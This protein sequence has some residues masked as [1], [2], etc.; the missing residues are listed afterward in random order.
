MKLPGVISLRKLFADLP[1]SERRLAARGRH[2]IGEVD[3][4]A[5]RGLGA[6]IVQPLLGLDGPEIGLEHHVELAWLCPLPLGATVRADDLGHR[7]RI[8]IGDVLL[9]RVGLLHVVLAMPVVAAQALHQRVVEDL[10]VAGGHPHRP[11][12]D[13]RRVEPHHV[14]ATGDHSAPPLPLDVLLELHAQRTVI[15]RRFGAAVD[16]TRGKYEATPFGQVDYGVD[17]GR[18]E[19]VHFLPDWGRARGSGPLRPKHQSW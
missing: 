15:P 6:Q 11:R 4:D 13:D 18:Q 1:D 14:V 10:D 16:L 7:H 17:D 8:G 12:Q 19:D 5:L 9:G 3:E 2:H